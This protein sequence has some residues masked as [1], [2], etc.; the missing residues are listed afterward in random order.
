MA[1]WTRVQ[2][3]PGVQIVKGDVDR[4]E[5]D[6]AGGR[7]TGVLLDGG[8]SAPA[9]LVVDAS[10]RGSRLPTWLQEWGFDQ[11]RV[12]AVKVGSRTRRSGCAFRPG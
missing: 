8:V 12:D 10:G 5:F 1:V 6:S 2:A 7:V 4:P 3:L 11:P 9:D